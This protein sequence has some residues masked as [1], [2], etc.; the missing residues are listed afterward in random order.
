MFNPNLITRKE[1]RQ[2][3]MQEGHST[4][5]V[6]WTLK[7]KARVIKDKKVR[8]IALDLRD[9]KDSNQMKCMILIVSSIK[10]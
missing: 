5:K 4:D 8:G 3:K 2:I 7:K 9:Y 10:K 1:I 6:P